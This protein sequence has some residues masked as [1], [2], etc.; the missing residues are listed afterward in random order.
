MFQF[1]DDEPTPKKKKPPVVPTSTPN[2]NNAPSISSIFTSP[3]DSTG[4]FS[5][6]YSKFEIII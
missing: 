5:M 2:Q 1:L 4:L 6:Y 3:S